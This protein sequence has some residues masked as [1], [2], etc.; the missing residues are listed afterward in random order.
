M[1]E[2]VSVSYLVLGDPRNACKNYAKPLENIAFPSALAG[3]RS[4]ARNLGVAD[5]RWPKLSPVLGFAV[6][7][8]QKN[9]GIRSAK[10]I[11]WPDLRIPEFQLNA[12]TI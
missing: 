8:G 2:D 7:S 12:Y 10:G 3:T 6:Y 5:R 1:G 11:R 9:R 4:T